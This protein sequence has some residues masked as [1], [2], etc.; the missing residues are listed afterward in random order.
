MMAEAA[1]AA[2][3]KQAKVYQQ[4]YEQV[5][6]AKTSRKMPVRV[7]PVYEYV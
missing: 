4:K 5:M 1:A 3:N 6:Q 7:V 2:C